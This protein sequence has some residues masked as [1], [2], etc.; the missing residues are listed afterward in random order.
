MVVKFTNLTVML[1][2]VIAAWIALD[3]PSNALR[4]VAHLMVIVMAVVTTVVNATLL[5]PALPPGW[6]GV[7]D[8]FQHWLIPLALVAL[9]AVLGPRIEVPLHRLGGI[10]VIPFLWLVFV[11]TRGSMTDRYPYDFLD[12]GRNGWPSVL[13]MAAAVLIAM[14]TIGLAL[15]TFDRR[16]T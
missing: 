14:V 3:G 8:L 7:V 10:V 9:W 6:W 4:T 1:V 16:R 15:T 5:D 11:L 12:V 13:A 2:A